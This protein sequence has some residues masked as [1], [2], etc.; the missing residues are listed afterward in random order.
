MSALILFLMII[1]IIFLII[2]SVFYFKGDIVK[3]GPTGPTGMS[4]PTGSL[5]PTGMSGHTGPTGMS[6]IA[7]NTGATGPPGLPGV[8][9]TLITLNSGAGGLSNQNFIFYGY[10][11]VNEFDAQIVISKPGTLSNLYVSTNIPNQDS[12]LFTVYV[13]GNPTSLLVSM[14]GYISDSNNTTSIVNVNPGDRVSVYF[15]VSDTPNY[16]ACVTYTI[17][18]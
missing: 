17:T 10:Q 4:G 13:N 1:I 12:K 3:A 5:G 14:S 15:I 2:I 6:G 9:K 18:S 11:T 8:N 16:S 7:N